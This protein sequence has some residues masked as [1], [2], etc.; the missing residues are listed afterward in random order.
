MVVQILYWLPA[1]FYIVCSF[2][3]IATTKVSLYLASVNNW[4][5]VEGNPFVVNLWQLGWGVA[6]LYEILW[7]TIMLFFYIYS[8]KIHI[9]IVDSG[10]IFIVVGGFRFYASLNN[11]IILWAWM[12]DNM[13]V[14]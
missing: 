8:T 4:G 6:E 12:T 10:F 7:F 9:P 3:D 13:G 5:I 11:V 14:L 1:I 2:F